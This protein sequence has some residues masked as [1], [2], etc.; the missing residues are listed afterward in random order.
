MISE[1]SSTN[2]VSDRTIVVRGAEDYTQTS[3]FS[4]FYLVDG[5]KLPLILLAR[6]NTARYRR[7]V[8]DHPDRDYDLGNSLC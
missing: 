8:G 1:T 4:A 7:Q 2:Q 3:K 6:G 5:T